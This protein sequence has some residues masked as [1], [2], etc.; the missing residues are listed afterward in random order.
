MAKRISTLVG[1]SPSLPNKIL[2]H[3]IATRKSFT[4]LTGLEKEKKKVLQDDNIVHITAQKW[5][6]YDFEK[7]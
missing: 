4:R 5:L 1:W 2:P 7:S 3:P 6:I